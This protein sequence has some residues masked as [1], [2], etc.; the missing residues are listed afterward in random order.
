MWRTM[1]RTI[2]FSILCFSMAVCSAAEPIVGGPCDGCEAVFV[3]QP[4]SLASRSRIAP[5]NEAGEPMLITGRVLA[6]DGKPKTNVIVYAYHTDARGIYPAPAKSLGDAAADRHGRL[7]GWTLTDGEGRYT[8]ETIRPASY[9]S[10]KIP[11]H[12]HM[13]V[14]ERGCATYYLDD[15]V[16]TDDTLLTSAER[17]HHENPRGGSGVV[18]PTRDS[19]S[20]AWKVVRDIRLGV[21]IP[22]HPGC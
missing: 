15:I 5:A 14:I 9:P 7:R 3:G 20:G 16:F 22:G 21:N 2:R 10:R 19:A 6:R 13:H 11:A 8:F 4:Q 1:K 17:A 18:T 12:V